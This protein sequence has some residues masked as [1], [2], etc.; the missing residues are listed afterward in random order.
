MRIDDLKKSFSLDNFLKINE[1]LVDS[2]FTKSSLSLTPESPKFVSKVEYLGE[3]KELG[4]H[5]LTIEHSSNKDARVG[6][7][8]DIFRILKKYTFPN[9]L[10]ASYAK[11]SEDWRYSLVTTNLTI[12]KSGKITREFSN[13]RRYSFILGPDQKVLTP[14]KQLVSLGSVSSIDDLAKRFSIEVVNK[15]FY[16]SIARLYTKLIGGR[17]V[18]SSGYED[19]PGL[20]VLNGTTNQSK[21]HQEFAVRLI[22]RVVFC[23]FLKEK[24][25]KNGVSLIPNELISK[26]S[27]SRF[28]QYFHE[29][30][31]PIFFELLNKPL[32]SRNEKFA[33]KPFSLIPY[34]NGGL[35]TPQKGVGGD[36]YTFNPETGTGTEGKITIP[37]AWFSEL[38]EL[39]ETYNFT[40]DENTPFDIE[41]S[42][43]PEMLGRIFENL[44]AEINPETG[45]TARKN[46]GSFYTPREIVD[47]MVDKSLEKYLINST[48]LSKDK[49]RSLITYDLEDD[50]IE[51]RTPEENKQVVQSL[52]KV[53][54]IDPACGSG[55]FPIGV[56]QKIVF[57][58]QQVDPDSYHWLQ[59]QLTNV[60]PELRRHLESQFEDKNYDYLRKL[61]VIRK[62]IY[63]VDI[64][65]IA[66]E[67]ARLRCF[68]TLV[69]EENVDDNLK[70]RGLETLPNLDFKFVTANS[71]VRLPRS[72]DH[73]D[74]S[75]ELFE[76]REHINELKTLRNNYFGANPQERLELQAEFNSL[77]RKMAIKNQD[78][79]AGSGSPLYRELT[80][81]EPFEH[82]ATEWFDPE[83]IFGEE[84]KFD[85]AIGN[86]PWE[87]FKPL[88]PEFFERYDTSYRELSKRDQKLRKSELL[89]D[90]G[91][92]KSYEEYISYYE[93]LGA[94]FRESYTLQGSGD[95]NLYKLF[96]EMAYSISRVMTLLVP[97][98][99]TVDKGGKVFREEFYKKSTL[100]TIVGLSNKDSLFP[101][102]DNNQKFVVIVL[103]SNESHQSVECLG[104]ISKTSQLSNDKL[105]SIETNFFE[106]FDENKT[107]F[108]DTG[109]NLEL[110]RRIK[111]SEKIHSLA[112][113]GYNYWGEYHV[114]NDSDYFDDKSGKTMLFSGKAIDQFDGMSK[115]WVEKHGRS[116]IWKIAGFPKSKDYCTEYYVDDIPERIIANHKK[117]K[118]N[119]RI[120]IQTVTGAVNNRRTLYAA[121]LPK[122]YLT[123]NSLGN[124]YIGKN[125]KELLFYLAI[126]NSLVV[127]WQAR[128]KVA[129]NL[130]KFILDT[131]LIPKYDECDAEISQKII[132]LC[133]AL[134]CVNEEYNDLAKNI[135]NK[136]FSQILISN[137]QERIHYQVE[138][139]RLVNSLFELEKPDVK[140]IN[141]TFPIVD[142]EFKNRIYEG[143]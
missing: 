6:V 17:R 36:Y 129:T 61:G 94:Y 26:E 37:N 74:G 18:L 130:N 84:D 33:D 137:E 75:N 100:D 72:K 11:G 16:K 85:I 5:I 24:K 126:L 32:R 111:S 1:Q 136:D 73:S 53:T 39:L 29:V 81:W 19:F 54:V 41:L 20:L 42:V 30:L 3:Y 117:D 139:N 88:D 105:I 79:Y 25:S 112:S 83:W 128:L 56:L 140:F 90:P 58:L 110:I 142:E 122:Q 35:F 108:I 45:E 134:S 22:G 143:E 102:I 118:G 89:K 123:N 67:I 43:D 49:I 68:L 120:V 8:T 31:E 34:L 44:L 103:D 93:K 48:T 141:S 10:I 21:E 70:N 71:L 116:S 64:Q 113:I 28:S 46:T 124:L 91:V 4:L 77:Q 121:I 114:T 138:I 63:G 13:P 96:L 97:G 131:L 132:E 66:T 133:A 62:S 59:E 99:I 60:S 38:F 55:A 40:V 50:L 87:K 15:E 109:K 82:S 2:E 12:N 135:F 92:S 23:W 119:Y 115:Y 51:P 127:D 47:F 95:L 52:A 65:P 27:V 69:V 107:I 78:E 76:D 125:D 104:W 98:Q 7:G 14:Y 101:A 57:I 106:N 86:P 80:R 9:A